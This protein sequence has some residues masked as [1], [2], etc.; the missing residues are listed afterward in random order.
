LQKQLRLKGEL[1]R[2]VFL[3]QVMGEPM[4]IVGVAV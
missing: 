2:V 3:T 1:E 4:V